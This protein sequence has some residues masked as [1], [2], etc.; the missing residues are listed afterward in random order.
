MSEPLRGI[1][2]RDDD[3][4]LIVRASL[5]DIRAFAARENEAVTLARR[6]VQVARV[7]IGT[8]VFTADGRAV[9]TIVDIASRRREIDVTPMGSP[10][11]LVITGNVE[12]TLTVAGHYGIGIV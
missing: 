2:L 4:T 3:D 11:R 8:P 9:G 7:G 10:T 1:V 5:D 12:I 6:P